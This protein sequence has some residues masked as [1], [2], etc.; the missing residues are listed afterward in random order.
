MEVGSRRFRGSFRGSETGWDM[1]AVALHP[2][3]PGQSD[4]VTS[5]RIR[6]SYRLEYAHVSARDASERFL[7]AARKRGRGGCARERCSSDVDLPRRREE[8][9]DITI[10]AARHKHLGLFSTRR[11]KERVALEI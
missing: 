3:M 10:A 6:Q 7:R 5:N 9:L 4:A 2:R 1:V 8:H 11:Y